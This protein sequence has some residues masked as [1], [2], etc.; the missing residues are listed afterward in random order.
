MAYF[1][2]ITGLANRRNFERELDQYF[3]QHQWGR[4]IYIDIDAFKNINEDYGYLVGD[5][6]LIGLAERLKN[7][8]KDAFVARVA[9]DE[10]AVV[11]GGVVEEEQLAATLEAFNNNCCQIAVGDVAL[12]YK[13]NMVQCKF[14]N[15]GKNT[16][17]IFSELLNRMKQAKNSKT[18]QITTYA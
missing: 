18:T 12:D 7:V 6:V 15:D 11:I 10:F 16:D 17:E 8:F 5:Q 1:D 9:G 4:I 3:R 2:Q 14:P 13:V